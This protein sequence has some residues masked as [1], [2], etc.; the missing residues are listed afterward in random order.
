MKSDEERGRE[1]AK[2]AGGLLNDL[3]RAFGEH[4]DEDERELQAI[5]G[6]SWNRSDR[7]A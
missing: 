5:L 4:K 6:G 2:R 7:H 3:H 1:A